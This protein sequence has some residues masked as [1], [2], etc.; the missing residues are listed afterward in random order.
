MNVTI[1]ADGFGTHRGTVVPNDQVKKGPRWFILNRPSGRS[2][3]LSA[4]VVACPF[5]H[6]GL[7]GVGI[8]VA[9]SLAL[10]KL[11]LVQLTITR[12]F[13]AT[14]TMDVLTKVSLLS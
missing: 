12:R 8:W 9:F 6:R 13:F 5:T 2:S 10:M 14:I 7:F 11:R 4:V 1:N 3:S